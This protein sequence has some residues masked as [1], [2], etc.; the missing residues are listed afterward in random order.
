MGKSRIVVIEPGAKVNSQYY[1]RNLLGD[2]LLPDKRAICQHHT[3]T[4]QQDGTPSHTARNTMEYLRREN[5]SFI[6]PDM[7]PP[8][9]PDLNQSTTLFGAPF[10]RWYTV[11]EVSLKETI[12]TE[13]TKLSQR[14]IDRA[15]DQWRRRLQC[16]VQQQGGHIEHFM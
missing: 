11:V 14:F 10:N 15:I 9:S 7:W 16:V 8:N 1:C 2:G 12:V 5:I 13:W 4:L 3:W 6:E